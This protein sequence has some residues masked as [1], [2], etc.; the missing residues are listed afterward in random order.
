MGSVGKATSG[1]DNALMDTFFG[2]THS[3]PSTVA[4]PS[5]TKPFTPQRP[6]RHDHHKETLREHRDRQTLHAET[7]VNQ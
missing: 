4:R 1:C 5:N 3:E 7:E 6:L 2:L